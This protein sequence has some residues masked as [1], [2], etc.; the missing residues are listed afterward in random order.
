MA[1]IEAM[2]QTKA[3]MFDF[4]TVKCLHFSFERGSSLLTACASL[5]PTDL[6]NRR[7]TSTTVRASDCFFRFFIGDV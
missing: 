2:M 5:P 4:F 6:L 7:R 1:A 3:T